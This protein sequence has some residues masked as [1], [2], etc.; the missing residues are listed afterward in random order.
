[1]VKKFLP[2]IKGTK[3]S[4]KFTCKALVITPQVLEKIIKFFEND[5]CS[6]KKI[7]LVENR[8]KEQKPRLLSNK[9]QYQLL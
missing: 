4:L 1:M 5:E 3:D 2:T 9:I 7:Y 6:W 8:F